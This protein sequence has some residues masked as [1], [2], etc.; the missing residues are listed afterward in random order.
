MSLAFD[1]Q[2]AVDAKETPVTSDLNDRPLRILMPSYRSHPHT[3]GQGVYMRHVTKGLVDRGHIV[4]VVSGPPYP[5][6]DPRVGL[7]K[8][9]SLDLYAQPTNFLGVPKFPWGRV[10]TT[11]DFLE[12]LI[13][14]TGGFGEPYTFGRRMAQVI[15]PKIQQYDVVH[16]NQSLGWGLLELRK[17][18]VAVIGTIHHPITRD[19]RIAI[20][21]ADTISLRLL[22][23]RW[24]SFLR[25]QMKVARELDPIIVV[26]ESTKRDVQTDFGIEEDRIRL[27]FH[28]IDH[29]Q[30]RPIPE[31][32]RKKNRIMTTTSA[33]V[34][35]KGLSYLV[36]AFA[37]LLQTYPDLELVIIGKLRD[38]PTSKMIERLG[39]GENIQFISGVTDE[40]ITRL[41][42]ETTVAVCPS[43]YEG[44][45]FPPG[46][47]MAC[48]VPVVTTTG[49]AL[50]E[51][52]GDAGVLVPPGDAHA[53]AEGVRSLLV[54]ETK[55]KRLGLLGRDRVL[56]EFNWAR[57]AENL[58]ALYRRTLNDA[59]GSTRVAQS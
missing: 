30:F 14:V 38:G 36:S 45:G 27:V 3:G 25:M 23:R 16:D 11:T 32:K 4:D 9:P 48:G 46:E 10:K 22:T 26:S 29:H 17:P 54:D 42:A 31:I 33:D 13:H 24:Y 52:V 19:K 44:F 43:I 50:P 39:I 59:Y 57:T 1:T 47:A 8:L 56:K 37:E 51:V 5:E 12:Y 2:D 15:G 21:H 28:G 20:E 18:G 34:A 40:E 55:R 7:I 41:Y 35:M 53:L 58:E 49:G 6:L